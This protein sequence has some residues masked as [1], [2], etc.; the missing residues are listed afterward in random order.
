MNLPTTQGRRR[1]RPPK[2][3]AMASKSNAPT[4]MFANANAPFASDRD[5]AMPGSP[6]CELNVSAASTPATALLPSAVSF[7]LPAR[8]LAAPSWPFDDSID[9]LSWRVPD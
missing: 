4:G 6:L 5:T 3:L 1:A 7:L 8:L 9:V 2:L